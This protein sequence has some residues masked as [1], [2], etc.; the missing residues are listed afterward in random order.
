MAAATTSA[1]ANV[2]EYYESELLTW[3]DEAF[4][5]W[6]EPV[7]VNGAL[8]DASRVL[9][10]VAPTAYRIEFINWLT[11]NDYTELPSGKYALVVE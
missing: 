10:N 3:F 7:V 5:E 11:E 8:Y 9:R 2:Q 4:D 1:A 6:N